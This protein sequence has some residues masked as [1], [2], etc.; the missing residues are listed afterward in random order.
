MF[1]LN[2]KK[3]RLQQCI[4][5]GVIAA[6]LLN[7]LKVCENASKYRILITNNQHFLRDG[8]APSQ[9]LP[10]VGEGDTSFP[11]PTPLTP[12]ASHAA[13][14]E[15]WLQTCQCQIFLPHAQQIQAVLC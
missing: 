13:L 12:S 15:V 4:G 2:L 6:W 8:T 14:P 3:T 10:P 1:S 9:T 5:F 11:N 7:C